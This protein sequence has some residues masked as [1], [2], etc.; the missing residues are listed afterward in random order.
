MFFLHNLQ[1]Q[2]PI[3]PSYFGRDIKENLKNQLYQEVEGLCTGEY[4]IVA[5]VDISDISA[6]KI[7]P[8]SGQAEYTVYYRAIVWKPFRGET[9]DALVTSVKY[10]GIFAE[11][12]PLSVFVSRQ[13]IPA[14][15]KWDGDATP[16]QYTNGADEV[17]E[18]GSAIRLKIIGLRS[19]I[20]QIYAIGSI[21]EDYHGVSR[22]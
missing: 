14:D 9:V 2:I 10:Q 1:K 15:I 11:V 8:G 22:I 20:A 4:Y 5:I 6:G 17:I 3:H 12:G 13:L 19:D 18:K 16:P 21:S 7:L